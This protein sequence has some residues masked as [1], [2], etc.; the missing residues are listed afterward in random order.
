MSN[1]NLQQEPHPFT[2]QDVRRLA[3][4]IE[5]KVNLAGK[6]LRDRWQAFRPRLAKFERDVTATSTHAS[7]A[8]TK[9][10]SD[11]GVALKK[12]IDDLGHEG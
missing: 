1:Q 7:K 5:V 2:W 9:E 6:E 3:D 4:E 10:L 12:L 11:L 8:F